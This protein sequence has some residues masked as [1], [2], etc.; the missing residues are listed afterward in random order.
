MGALAARIQD[1]GKDDLFK[2]VDIGRP[3]DEMRPVVEHLNKLL[4]RLEASFTRRARF[5]G[6]RGA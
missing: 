3:P 4:A 5:H 1:I 6:R 2:P